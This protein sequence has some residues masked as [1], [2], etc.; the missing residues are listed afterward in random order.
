LVIEEALR[1]RCRDASRPAGYAIDFGVLADGQTAIVEVNDG[2]GLGANGADGSVLAD[3]LIA[4]W[5][6][7]FS[8]P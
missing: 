6:Q 5:R 4:R 3:V 7:L 2:L 1:L 8:S